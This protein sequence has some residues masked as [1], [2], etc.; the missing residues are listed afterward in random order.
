MT[1]VA[2]PTRIEPSDF[3]MTFGLEGLLADGSTIVVGNSDTFD[4]RVVPEPGTALLM[5]LGLAALGARRR[6]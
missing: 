1:F 3:T 6:A 5:G 4:L 2:N